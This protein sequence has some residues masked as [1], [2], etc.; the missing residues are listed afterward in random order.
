MLFRSAFGETKDS[1]RYIETRWGSGYRYVGPFA[2]ETS[3]NG[4][5]ASDKTAAAGYSN[6]SIATEPAGATAGSG[7]LRGTDDIRTAATAAASAAAVGNSN[8]S[9]RVYLAGAVL[10][11][12]AVF[13][14]VATERQGRASGTE[15]PVVTAAEPTRSVAVLPLR[16]DQGSAEDLYLGEIGRASCRERV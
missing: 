9:I 6:G 14:I 7:S 1:S 11:A 8:R 3:A 16:V 13:G 4:R 15:A 12:G 10:L 5:E 2:E